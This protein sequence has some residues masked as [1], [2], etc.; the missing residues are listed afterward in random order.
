[1]GI[2]TAT[3]AGREWGYDGSGLCCRDGRLPMR[4]RF[5][6]EGPQRGPGDE[7]SLKIE[8]VVDGGMDAKEALRGSS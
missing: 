2:V 8:R 6:S 1:M 3:V 7:V 4:R 5:G